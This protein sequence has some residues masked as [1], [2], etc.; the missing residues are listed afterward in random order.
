[1]LVELLIFGGIWFWLLVGIEASLIFYYVYRENYYNVCFFSLLGIGVFLVFGDKAVLH[2]FYTLI[3]EDP[4]I[5]F[6]YIGGYIGLGII[7][8]FIKMYFSTAGVRRII[9]EAKLSWEKEK[10][11]DKKWKSFNSYL[12]SQLRYENQ[13]KLSFDY[14]KTKIINWITYWPF[15]ALVTLLNDPFRRLINFIFYNILIG[16]YRKI[17][18]VMIGSLLEE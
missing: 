2:N 9:K 13:N 15:S 5:I 16:I 1:M 17:H 4:R 10:L 14:Y 8:S 12:D 7:W 3:K 18:S 11:D 6:Q